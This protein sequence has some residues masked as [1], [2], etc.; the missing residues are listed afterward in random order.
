MS[1]SLALQLSRVKVRVVRHP[2][3]LERLAG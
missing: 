2:S 1:S 3:D